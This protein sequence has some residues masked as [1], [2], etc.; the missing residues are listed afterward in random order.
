MIGIRD[1]LAQPTCWQLQKLRPMG[2]VAL[3]VQYHGLLNYGVDSR[4]KNLC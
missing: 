3:I 2:K 1:P 4:T